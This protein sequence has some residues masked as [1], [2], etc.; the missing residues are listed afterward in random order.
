MRKKFSL[1]LLAVVGAF[2]VAALTG[3]GP[4]GQQGV[5][6]TK[7]LVG[8]T[9]ATSGAFATVGVPFNAALKARFSELNEA[10]GFRERKI[11]LK[12]YDDTF[13]ATEGLTLTKKLVE[14]DKIFA[15]V[16]HFGTPTVG[17]TIDYIK[18]T[19]IPMVY[20]ATG[21]NALYTEKEEGNPVFSVQ[22]IYLTEGRV[23]AARVLAEVDVF[24]PVTKV[25]AFYTAEDAGR[26]ILAG[27]EQQFEALGRKNQLVKFEGDPTASD[28][29][30]I[31]TS[32]KESGAQVIIGASNQIPFGKLMSSLAKL[33]VELP[34]I[35]SYVNANVTAIPKEHLS[36][37]RRVYAN[38]WVDV[39]SEEF[40][41]QYS[42]FISTIDGAL[43]VG[44]I[45]A[46]EAEVSKNA[47]FAY[48]LAGYIAAETFIAGLNALG[49][50]EDIT[51]ANYIKALESKPHPLPFTNGVDFTEGK[52]WGIDQ[53]VLTQRVF[54]PKEVIPGA[55]ADYDGF[56]KT[57]DAE[58]LDSILER[59]PAQG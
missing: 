45:S 11:E 29:D 3:C 6:K 19:G 52:R 28:Y 34:V 7:I 46:D 5:T 31:A 9:A 55:E 47:G 20:A 35:T 57:K 42:K 2:S 43:E 10:G 13:S 41:T 8:N 51:W 59:I 49:E 30:S 53:L 36:L 48:G 58:P 12:H 26:S 21:I 4:R 22:P 18:E 1:S 15:L 23:M 39:Y 24:G 56:I 50:E 14:D 17:A 25:A 40:L 16:G 27:V 44:A 32:I 33:E 38:A 37:G 54:I